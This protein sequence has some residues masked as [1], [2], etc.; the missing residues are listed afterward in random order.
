MVAKLLYCYPF[1]LVSST[2]VDLKRLS[3]GTNMELHCL[4]ENATRRGENRPD[5]TF[6]ASGTFVRYVVTDKVDDGFLR[7]L[8]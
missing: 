3:Q 2:L 8:T 4:T 5:L 6:I 7:I 1:R